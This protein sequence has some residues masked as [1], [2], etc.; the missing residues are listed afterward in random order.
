MLQG[1]A[2]Y[3]LTLILIQYW[4]GAENAPSSESSREGAQA[5][6]GGGVEYRIR[7]VRGGRNGALPQPATCAS[8]TARQRERSAALEVV[9][10]HVSLHLTSH[11][12]NDIARTGMVG[13]SER[14]MGG[15]KW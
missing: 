11:A 9:G 4:V 5:A 8:F 2:K 10:L 15:G 3:S 12:M 1:E 6:H 13:Y 14:E 7:S